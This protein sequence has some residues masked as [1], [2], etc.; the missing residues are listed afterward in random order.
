ME[1][2]EEYTHRIFRHHSNL[3]AAIPR[4]GMNGQQVH[5]LF[6]MCWSDHHGDFPP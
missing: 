4:K 2:R 6:N 1:R 5:S 3:C